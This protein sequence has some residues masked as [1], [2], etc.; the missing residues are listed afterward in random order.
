MKR[1][2]VCL[3]MCGV[4]TIVFSSMVYDDLTPKWSSLL[5]LGDIPVYALVI[6]GMLCIGAGCLLL[7]EDKRGLGGEKRVGAWERN[8]TSSFS[9]AE[10][11]I[12]QDEPA[13]V[14]RI[15]KKASPAQRTETYL[16]IIT[17]LKQEYGS[18]RF[19]TKDAAKLVLDK[20][21]ANALITRSAFQWGRMQ[22]KIV[23]VAHGMYQ[24]VKNA[25]ALNRSTSEIWDDKGS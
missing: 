6:T 16:E 17:Q 19:K 22:G 13:E 11:G 25:Q 21:G 15:A 5:E 9:S 10:S 7:L 12:S 3:L 20:L 18:D 8:T 24:F 4:L 14:V 23:R 2:A 1:L